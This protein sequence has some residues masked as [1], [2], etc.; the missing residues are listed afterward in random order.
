MSLDFTKLTP[1]DLS[2]PGTLALAVTHDVR[3]TPFLIF[4]PIQH[5]SHSFST[6]YAV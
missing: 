6:S 2:E 4:G 3:I 5:V 1:P